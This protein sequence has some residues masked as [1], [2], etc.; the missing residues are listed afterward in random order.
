MDGQAAAL[1]QCLKYNYSEQFLTAFMQ[2][3]SSSSSSSSS[4]FF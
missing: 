2:I 1:L 3:L 4:S